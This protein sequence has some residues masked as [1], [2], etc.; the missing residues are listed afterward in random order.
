MI[1]VIETISDKIT[2]FIYRNAS[3]DEDMKEIYKYGIEI[4]ISSLL[5]VVLV[6][7]CAVFTGDIINGIT[8]LICLIPMRSYCGGYHASTYLKCNTAMLVTFISVIT[9]NFIITQL[10]G[11]EIIVLAVLDIL[12]FVPIW[13]FA[14]VKNPN[15]E[16]DDKKA[17]KCRCISVILYIFWSM[18]GYALIVADCMYGSIIIITLTAISVLILLEILL[19][20]R[21]KNG[22]QE[23]GC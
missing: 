20:R 2:M 11:H 16:L 1:L 9:V 13:L 12:A 15:K 5:N 10:V 21:D 8:Y 19:R 14:P 18:T 17:R 6:L 22:I 3:L 23:D 7:L 4:T